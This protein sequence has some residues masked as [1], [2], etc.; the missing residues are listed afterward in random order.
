MGEEEESERIRRKLKERL[1]GKASVVQEVKESE[2]DGLRLKLLQRMRQEEERKQ[3]EPP[4]VKKKKKIPVKKPAELKPSTTQPA[5]EEGS[6]MNRFEKVRKRL[7]N[8]SSDEDSE[9][10]RKKTKGSQYEMMKRKMEKKLKNKQ[11]NREIRWRKG[12]EK[13]VTV[14]HVLK[15][16]E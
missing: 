14:L 10:E 11:K 15:E 4:P 3:Q 2:Q 13:C 9:E 1:Q 6:I 8:E 7:R 16:M 12:E 5:G